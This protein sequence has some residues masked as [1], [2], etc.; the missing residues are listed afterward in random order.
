MRGE[1]ISGHEEDERSGFYLQ[2]E[3][4]R[5]EETVV[6]PFYSSNKSK[7]RDGQHMKHR[8]WQEKEERAD[9]SPM[10]EQREGKIPL[11]KP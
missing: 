5:K 7:K 4:E 6:F 2:E 9:R 1:N 11:S 3:S 10:Q 8:Q